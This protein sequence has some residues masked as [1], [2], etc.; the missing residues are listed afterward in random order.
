MS[1]LTPNPLALALPSWILKMRRA[2]ARLLLAALFG[3]HAVTAAATPYGLTA[4]EIAQLAVEERS[5]LARPIATVVDKPGPSPT[6]DSHDYVSYARYYWPNPDTPDGLPFVR[7][8]GQHNRAQVAQG[9]HARLWQFCATVE[10]LAAAWTVNQNP[11]VAKRAG[12]WLRA[13]FITPTTRMNPHVEYAQIRLGHHGN[14]GTEFGVLDARCLAQVIDGLRLLEDSPALS[15]TETA[16]VQSWFSTYLQWLTTSEAGTAERANTNNHGTWYI[17]QAVPI[18]LYLGHEDL[19]RELCESEKL[20][21]AREIEP[22][23]RQPQEITRADGLSYSQFN[24]EAHASVARL[25]A[26][27]GLD[28]W[29]YTAP[30]GAN[31]RQALEFLRPYNSAP[32]T[33]PFTQGHELPAG[34]LDQL[35]QEPAIA[36]EKL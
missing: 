16:A 2:H 27:L 3:G 21:I 15:A 13:W 10:S 30:N 1:H 35:L 14:R 34:F 4:E 9:D 22:D 5:A 6:G 20:R 31:L 12:D 8:D 28:L 7:R 36:Q 17:A 11:A 24:L 29:N 19:A 18:A 25:A 32:E 33:W 26:N 23:G